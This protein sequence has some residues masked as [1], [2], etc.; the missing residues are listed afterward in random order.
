MADQLVEM[1]LEKDIEL[2]IQKGVKTWE[3]RDSIR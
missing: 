2:I 3:S 1:T